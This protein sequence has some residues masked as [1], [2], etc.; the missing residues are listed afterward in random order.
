MSNE[1]IG[2]IPFWMVK[3]AL[4]NVIRK[5]M[6][7]YNEVVLPKDESKWKRMG[8]LSSSKVRKFDFH[9]SLIDGEFQIKSIANGVLNVR[10]SKQLS[11]IPQTDAVIQDNKSTPGLVIKKEEE[12]IIITQ[13]SGPTVFIVA[14]IDK[15]TSQITFEDGFG[16]QIYTEEFPSYHEEDWYKIEKLP[17]VAC[18]NYY[19][20]G[21]KGGPLNK[22][23]E[24]IS[25][26]NTDSFSYSNNDSKLYQS[27]P[28]QIVVRSNGFCYA[29]VYDNPNRSQIEIGDDDDC[30]TKYYVN[31]GGI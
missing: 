24:T 28:I 26:W 9:A 19:G 15:E 20:F 12:K 10:I 21:E 13:E 14:I 18:E 4:N 17:G 2:R 1:L 6:M 27:Q 30:S 3:F 22:K 31:G 23:G 25:F 5:K 8:K 7:K 11:D 29:I 16:F